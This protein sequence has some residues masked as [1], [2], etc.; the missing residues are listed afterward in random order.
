[1]P[2]KTRDGVCANFNSIHFA[3]NKRQ[4]LRLFQVKTPW[5]QAPQCNCQ[6]IDV[7]G[8]G[9]SQSHDWK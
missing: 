6:T 4:H 1:M 2:P 8:P 3:A 7:V 9:H 5:M